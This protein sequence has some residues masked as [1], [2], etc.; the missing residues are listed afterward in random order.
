MKPK[1][2]GDYL[3]FEKVANRFVVFYD[4]YLNIVNG[5]CTSL[6]AI[7][8]YNYLIELKREQKRFN[9]ICNCSIFRLYDFVFYAGLFID[10]DSG[11]IDCKE[12]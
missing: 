7:Y 11:I 8:E 4:V 10:L 5:T 6:E 9:N 2:I 12:R 3:A 1:I